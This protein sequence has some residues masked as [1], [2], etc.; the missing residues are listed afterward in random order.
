MMLLVVVEVVVVVVVCVCVCVCVCGLRGR[1]RGREC[2]RNGCD[3]ASMHRYIIMQ[4]LREAFVLLFCY[5]VPRP[6]S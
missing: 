4:S 6:P 1:E 2:V 3:C 5:P